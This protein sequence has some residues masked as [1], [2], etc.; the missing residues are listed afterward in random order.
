MPDYPYL[1][2]H[3]KPGY[4]YLKG[5]VA[6]YQVAER[7]KLESFIFHGVILDTMYAKYLVEHIVSQGYRLDAHIEITEEDGQ[8]C[9]KLQKA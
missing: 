5:L 7:K 6:A 9:L 4:I 8:P 3:V 2:A 1:P